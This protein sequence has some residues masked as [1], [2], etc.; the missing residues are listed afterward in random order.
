MISS[1]PRSEKR[2]PRLYLASPLFILAAVALTGCA[3]PNWR[4]VVPGENA[5]ELRATLGAPREIYLLPDGSRRWFYPAPGQTR[6]AA[7]IDHSGLVVSVRQMLSAE[8]FG[9]ARIGEWTTRDVLTRFG[10]P[11]E[12]SHFPLMHREVWSYRFAQDSMAFATMHFYFDP[13]GVLRLTQVIP[14]FLMDA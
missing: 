5:A 8:E 9:R 4:S 3:S 10:T 1:F 13:A 2:L 6:W 7:D 14:D 11:D 12:T